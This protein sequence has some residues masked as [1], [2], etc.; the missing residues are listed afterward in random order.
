MKIHCEGTV[1]MEGGGSSVVTRDGPHHWGL[2]SVSTLH[3]QASAGDLPVR[4]VD[5]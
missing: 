2:S 3:R 1:S 4:L 5:L